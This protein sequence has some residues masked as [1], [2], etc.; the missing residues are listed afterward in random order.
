MREA[1]DARWQPLLMAVEF[2]DL[3]L[4]SQCGVGEVESGE[5]N[6]LDQDRRARGTGDDAHLG[7]PDMSAIAVADRLVALHLE[8]DQL[9]LRML[10]PAQQ[11]FAAD[12]ILVLAL[13]GDSETDA[14]L[15]RV[16]LVAELIAGED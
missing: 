12:E 1:H 11:R 16:G 10:A 9:S 2:A 7:A 6:G 15:E 4:R 8:A 3:D 14:G 13:K 5:R